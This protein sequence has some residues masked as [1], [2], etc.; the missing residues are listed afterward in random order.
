MHLQT[1][2]HPTDYSETS[3]AALDYAATLARDYGSRLLILHAVET[4]GPENV[5]YGEAASEPQPESY[6]RRL[7]ED[8]RKVR[9]SDPDIPVEYLLSDEDP[10][11]AITKTAASRNCDLIVLA[12]HG[13]HGLRRL[14]TGS[15]AERVVREAH[16]PVLVVKVPALSQ[17]PSR[18][19]G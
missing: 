5:S 18:A 13:H 14:L 2:L 19:K 12:S 17:D 4:L 3:A 8:L 9:P 6:R 11:T 10:A 1:I 7:W 15:V 16:C